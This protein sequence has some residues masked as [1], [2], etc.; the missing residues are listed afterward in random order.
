MSIDPLGITPINLRGTPGA[1]PKAAS[2]ALGKDEFLRLLVTQLSN[3]DPLNPMEGQ[4]FAAQLAQFT[5]VE[6]LI[7]IEQVL[8]AQ[9]DANA[10]L[11]QSM[12][13]GVAA[14]LIGKE[15]EAPGNGL[16]WDGES[17]AAGRFELEGNAASVTVSIKD[18][19][20]FVV[21][22]LEMGSL[23]SGEQNFTWDGTDASGNRVTAG[24]Y[25]TD[26]VALD[27]DGN[28]I[29]STSTV[30]GQVSKVTFSADGVFL[31]IGLLPVNMGDVESVG[32]SS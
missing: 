11:A 30:R 4:E 19:T 5:S 22:V 15:I 16:N 27:D 2:A 9:G 14:G 21:K 1:P 7:N 23:E 29:S 17:G 12:N 6:Q 3:Q 31:W 32:K 10:V 20:G 25:T 24:A 8:T 26:V 13:N 28:S 18:S